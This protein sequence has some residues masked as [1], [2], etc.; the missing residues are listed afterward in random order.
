MDISFPIILFNYLNFKY[1]SDESNHHIV[2][3]S[4]YFKILLTL[5][6]LTGL[7]VGVASAELV[8]LTI[9]VVIILTGIMAML[10]FLYY[11]HLSFDNKR[12]ALLLAAFIF[13]FIAVM[14][15]TLF[16]YYHR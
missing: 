13:I 15:I 12:S 7:I 2:K 14:I 5:L 9:S 16:D 8:P 4:Y 3:Y 10:M 1:V 6:V 11:M